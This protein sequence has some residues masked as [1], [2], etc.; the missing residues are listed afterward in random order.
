MAIVHTMSRRERIAWGSAAV[1]CSLVLHV[2]LLEHLPPLP[3]GRLDD[4]RQWPDYPSIALR[5]VQLHPPETERPPARFRPEDPDEVRMVAGEMELSAPA[6]GLPVPLAPP[7]EVST[8]PLK[9]EAQ[10]LH[11]PEFMAE[12]PPWDPREEIV[13][14]EQV[15]Q[16]QELAALPRRYTEATERT[17]RV[18][19][20]T[21]P[22]E[23]AVE[24]SSA[25]GSVEAPGFESMSR[26]VMEWPEG[27]GPSMLGALEPAGNLFTEA[28]RQAPPP[29][30][31]SGVETG[32][33]TFLAIDITAYRAEDEGGATYFRLEIR[34]T[35]ESA[36]PLL[37][38]D[39]LLLQ[40]SSE[41][42]TPE[43]LA[44]CKRGLRRWLDWIGSE[45]RF[46]IIGFSD[47]LVRCFAEPWQ[48]MNPET[49][50][51][52]I[53]FIGTLRASGNTDVYGS[54]AAASALP[55]DATRPM[56]MILVTD[57]RPTTG[58]TG[59]SEIIERFS[60]GNKEHLALFSVGAGR[61]ANRFLLDLLSYRNRGD[62]LVV[63]EEHMLVDAMD[64]WA[65]ETHRP[66]L[67]ELQYQLSGIDEKYVY[68]R[69]LTPLF[70]D[71]PLVLYGRSEDPG[72]DAAIRIVGNSA[73]TRRDLLFPLRL[74]ECPPGGPDIRQ[75]WAWHRVYH[76]ISEHTRTGDERLVSLIRDLAARYGLVV[77]YGYSGVLPRW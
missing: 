55:M 63:A 47:Q 58:V 13:A 71:R 59:S 77:P 32:A 53:D 29:D 65:R 54:L 25:L 23:S 75:R 28:G 48:R 37:P 50:R 30:T 72:R 24:I 43:K 38:K 21:L 69:A 10:A 34:R 22:L 3:L 35:A 20:I 62:S 1:L 51:Q 41:S 8:G 33:E 57:G 26:P 18:P 52:A 66:V 36:L 45:D 5:E 16:N 64:R 39:I 40:D 60:A 9:G 44:E 15:R 73:G 12:R 27:W 17:T 70:L 4:A 11:E 61:R 49:R 68:P 2:Y 6:G 67:T 7:P 14:I 31:G 76:L 74:H 56:L 46:Q 42:I 19:D